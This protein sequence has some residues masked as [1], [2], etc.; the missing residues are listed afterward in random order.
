MKLHQ[1]GELQ[2]L[3][4][5]KERFNPTFD[6]EYSGII[7]G[8]G[9]DAAVFKCPDEKILV[10]TDL[11]T[12]GIHFDLDYTS[13]FQLGFKLVSVNVSDIYAMGGIPKYIFLNIAMKKDI[14]EEFFWDFFKGISTANNIY[15][16]NLLGGDI[17]SA[18]NDM[19]VSATVVGMAAR[20]IKR[21]G[22]KVGD[23][24][25][26]TNTIG[27]SAC[28][29]EILK[30]LTPQSR[31][32]IRD[33]D[34]GFLDKTRELKGPLILNVNSKKLHLDFYIS[35][36]LI[37]RHLMP[38][39]RYPMEFIN[40]ATAMIDVSDGLFIDLNRLCEE[41]NTGA[42]IYLDKIPIS[43]NLRIAC[44]ML[45]LNPYNLA[46]SGGEDYELLFTSSVD[47]ENIISS[48]DK[49][50]ISCIGEIIAEKRVFITPDGKEIELKS[51]GYQ[52]FR[53]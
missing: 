48:N 28:G 10:T 50:S 52:H 9:D 31:D 44:E 37:K 2:L 38:T 27:D 20:I 34:F 13:S 8:I 21:S 46:S 41:S 25:Y 16:M 4:E 32:I 43:E 29:L 33:N 47:Y 14:S 11:M 15:G 40:N 39:V 36:P 23:K 17:S 35:E 3:R 7:V 19:M 12:E 51:D 1:K 26:L 22:A 6:K 49:I 5:I 45:Q 53:Y 30:R 24:I 18:L 42:R